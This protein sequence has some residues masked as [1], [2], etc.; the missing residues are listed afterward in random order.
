MNNSLTITTIFNNHCLQILDLILPIQQIEFNVPVTLEG[1][2]DL[3]DIET[4]YHKTGGGFWGAKN[5]DELV[6]SIA[7]IA[8][9]HNAGAIRKMFV[10]KEFRGK[11]NGTA[12]KLLGT[13]IE[14]CK[15]NGITDLYLGT[16]DMLK[17]AHR[18]YEKNGF[19]KMKSEEMPVYFPRMM[20]EN[21]YYHL[22]IQ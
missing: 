8:V 1:Q 3:L 9:G 10:K 11:E 18:F 12:Q 21:V 13:L 17:A 22:V 4:H 15:E 7:L 16:V 19:I 20:G 6:G 2:P 5:G 14:Y